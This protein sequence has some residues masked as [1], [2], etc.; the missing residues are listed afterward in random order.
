MSG[1]KLMPKFDQD[2]VDEVVRILQPQID[3]LKARPAGKQPVKYVVIYNDGS[4]DTFD[5]VLVV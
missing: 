4:T 1:D 5:L 2:A 3:E